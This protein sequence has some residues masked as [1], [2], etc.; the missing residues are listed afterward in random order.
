MATD[1]SV[2]D[3]EAWL[4]GDNNAD[5]QRKEEINAIFD[6]ATE[7]VV[8]GEENIITTNGDIQPPI[9]ENENSIHE[10]ENEATQENEEEKDSD[11]DE[12]S[13]D[14]VQVVIG[15]IKP[16]TTTTYQY[17]SAP[18][19]LNIKRGAG[20]AGGAGGS[21][22]SKTKGIDLETVGIINGVSIYEF[23]L[24]TI[25][26]KPWRKPGADITDY[27]NYGFN[28]DT[29]KA[30]CEKQRKLRIDNNIAPKVVQIIPGK[31]QQI[32]IATVNENSKYSGISIG[33]KKAG[34]P[35]GRRMSGSIDV[36]CGANSSR[37]SE[38]P[39]KM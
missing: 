19:N 24:D 3:D 39:K 32:P 5:E 16:A 25:E 13:D 38:M 31:D 18:V 22:A 36:I 15:D 11:D 12:D 23:N 33:A 2:D 37:R 8:P 27:F 10:D 17:G 20:F 6:R 26:D 35:P 21:A 1:V 7:D 28:E 34:P 4:Y 9:I 29:W 30:Y 14:D